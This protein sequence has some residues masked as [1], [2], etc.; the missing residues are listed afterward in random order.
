M[1]LLVRR[2]VLRSGNA[3]AI[4]IPTGIPSAAPTKEVSLAFGRD[5]ALA[6][7]SGHL[8]PLELAPLLDLVERELLRRQDA[9]AQRAKARRGTP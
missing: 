5:I 8:T 6:D 1:A 7:L 9:K 3:R 4:G 2:K